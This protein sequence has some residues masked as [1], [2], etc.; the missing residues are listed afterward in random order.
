MN[1]KNRKAIT[2]RTTSIIT[3]NAIIPKIPNRAIFPRSPIFPIPAALPIPA[4][5]NPIFKTGKLN[6]KHLKFF[7]VEFKSI[8]F[9]DTIVD[10]LCNVI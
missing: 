1:L 2:A 7:I 6:I 9:I 8:N 3:T 5:P 4:L 10:Y